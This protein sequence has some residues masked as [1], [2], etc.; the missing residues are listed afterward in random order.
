LGEL[1]AS[2]MV[3]LEPALKLGQK[4]GGHL[5]QGHVNHIGK[6]TGITNKGENYLVSISFPFVLQKYIVKEGSIA[7]DGISLTVAQINLNEIVCSIIPHTWKNTNLCYKKIGEKVN[8][9]VD[10]LAKY[11]ENVNVGS[12]VI[13]EDITEEWLKKIGY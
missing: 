4:L 10:I 1:K 13:K 12:T 3:N 9:E 2:A 6:I 7:I 8:I 5:V 11:A